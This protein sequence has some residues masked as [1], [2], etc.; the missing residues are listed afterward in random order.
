MQRCKQIASERMGLICYKGI[1]RDKLEWE[2]AVM[3]YA[4]GISL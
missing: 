2:L 1:I 4:N 3:Y